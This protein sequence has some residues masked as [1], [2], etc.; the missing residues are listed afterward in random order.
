MALK[1]GYNGVKKSILDKLLALA[2]SVIIKSIGDGLD[3]DE[4]TGELSSVASGLPDYVLNTEVD[5]GRKWVDG[6]EIYSKI[7]AVYKNGS[8]NTE[9]GW[10]QVSGAVGS[11][12]NSTHYSGLDTIVEARISNRNSTSTTGLTNAVLNF[13]NST[14]TFGGINF[15]VPGTAYLYCEYTKAE[16]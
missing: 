5:T 11:Y 1:A 6:K 14:A 9:D 4:T 2:G 16:I 13:T 7:T 3:Y 8:V 12:A 15:T 10:S